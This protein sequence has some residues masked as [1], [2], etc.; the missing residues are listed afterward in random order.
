MCIYIRERKEKKKERA[1]FDGETHEGQFSNFPPFC[2]ITHFNSYL[3]IFLFYN[4]RGGGGGKGGG[5]L[6]KN[7]RS[8]TTAA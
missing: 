1:C 6:N 2:G 7:K 5:L 8:N 4:K 3:Y